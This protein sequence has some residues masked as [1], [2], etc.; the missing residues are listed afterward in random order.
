M[1]KILLLFIVGFY[2]DKID[3]AIPC[4]SGW[5]SHANSC[6]FF[7]RDT[8]TWILAKM[9]CEAFRGHLV[10]IETV[11]ENSFIQHQINNLN[12]SFWIGASDVE[13]E[14]EWRWVGTDTTMSF[15]HWRLNEPD[16][17]DPE[18]ENCVDIKAAPVEGWNDENCNAQS[19]YICEATE[20]TEFVVG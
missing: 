20:D 8:Q 18:H 5:L 16:S 19:N 14:G 1:A 12:K 4:R 15:T 13:V 17:Y 9:Y 6:Y 11:F 3:A 10:E 2:I 7:S